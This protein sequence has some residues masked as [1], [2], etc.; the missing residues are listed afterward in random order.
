[1]SLYSNGGLGFMMWHYVGDD[2]VVYFDADIQPRESDF[3]V[4]LSNS[5]GSPNEVVQKS[6][7]YEDNLYAVTRNIIT[8]MYY[9]YKSI[10]EGINFT[11]ADSAF[12]E[13]LYKWVMDGSVIKGVDEV[14]EGF[15]AFSTIDNPNAY[16]STTSGIT[17]ADFFGESIDTC[18]S[19]TIVGANLEDDEGANDSGKA[20]IFENATGNLVSVLTNP[21][22]Y[23]IAADDEFGTKVAISESYAIVGVRKEE[24][25]G[26]T[27][28]GKAYI[29][30]VKS[31]TLLWVLDNP[32]S[33]GTSGA[34]F[35]GSDVSICESYAIV[36]AEGEDGV[37]GTSSGAAYIFDPRNGQLLWTLDNPNDYGT[38]GGDT[39]GI[40]VSISESY[41]IV[42][43]QYEDDATNTSSGKAYIFNPATG[44]KLWTLDKPN[45]YGTSENDFFG[46]TVAITESY[47][48][49]GSAEDSRGATDSGK[50]YIFNPATGTIL[51]TLDNPNGYNVGFS[52]SFGSS[53]AICESYAIVGA[54][55]EDDAGGL[56][57]GKAYI[58][59]PATGVKLWTLDNPNGHGTSDG[60]QFGY[61]VGI[62]ESYATASANQESDE[63]GTL[64]GKVYIFDPSNGVLATTLD[65][66]YGP[67]GATNDN[68]GTAV[69]I[70]DK[71]MIVTAKLE[72]DASGTSGGKAYIYS[73]DTNELL[74]TLDN[75]N[76]YDVS[77]GDNF[78]ISVAISES[79][80]IIGAENEDDAGGTSSGKAY[81]FDNSTGVL[82]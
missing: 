57:A 67:G 52:D 53:V 59:N 63:S 3:F 76:G 65:N 44:V 20:Y 64:T 14:F 70:C 49:I 60:D 77:A 82:L 66:V 8:N 37:G 81:I 55:L 68:F 46:K 7:V 73:A 31:G 69:A 23:N 4:S 24:D 42:G 56:S 19:Y 18:E 15:G 38:I 35:F 21:N 34:D 5:F 16:F 62:S 45:G 40:S 72:D 30:D 78:G 2:Y 48:I 11:I 9:V 36:G 29:F 51:W 50:A 1:M 71:Y 12:Y 28:A 58:F 17:T 39:F 22:G 79:Y 13:N 80:S 47:A 6:F 27:S 25:A 32:N 43:A 33:Y 10:D 74:W 26:G 61:S 41:A 54:H 75:P